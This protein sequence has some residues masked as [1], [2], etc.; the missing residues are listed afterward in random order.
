MP[1][2][3]PFPSAHY[4]AVSMPVDLLC[5]S[6]MEMKRERLMRGSMSADEGRRAA[7]LLERAESHLACSAKAAEKKA[8]AA[9]EVGA[10]LKCILTLNFE[11][12]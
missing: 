6:R 8:I 11:S 9:A 10:T 4:S 5:R 12:K 2:N 7:R 3:G 1:F